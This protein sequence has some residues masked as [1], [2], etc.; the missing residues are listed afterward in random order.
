MFINQIIWMFVTSSLNSHNDIFHYSN[1]SEYIKNIVK[2][3]Y[4]TKKNG[5]YRYWANKH[6]IEEA[7]RRYNIGSD[8]R[9]TWIDIPS[10]KTSRKANN[11]PTQKPP[12]LMERIIMSSTV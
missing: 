11:Y 5:T 4:I 3:S 9:N 7:E 8:I 10:N 12:K 2:V 6:S 1:N